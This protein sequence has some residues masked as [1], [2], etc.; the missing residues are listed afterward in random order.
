[1][2]ISDNRFNDNIARHNFLLDEFLPYLQYD[3][4]I[5]SITFKSCVDACIALHLAYDSLRPQS[6]TVALQT[7]MLYVP[8]DY[9]LHLSSTYLNWSVNEWYRLW[10]RR[11]MYSKNLKS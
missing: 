5:P 8:Y 1:M 10:Y 11:V 3:S 6:V 9:T 4:L 2:H 7:S